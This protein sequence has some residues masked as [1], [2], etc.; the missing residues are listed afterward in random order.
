[1]EFLSVMICIIFFIGWGCKTRDGQFFLKNYIFKNKKIFIV[2]ESFQQFQAK[3]V[4]IILILG[5]LDSNYVLYLTII[6]SILV[7]LKYII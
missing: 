6:Y 4:E 1:M 2:K 5:V 7:G 3:V